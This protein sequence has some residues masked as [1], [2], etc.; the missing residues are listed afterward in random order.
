MNLHY[1]NQ[2]FTCICDA[3]DSLITLGSETSELAHVM[4]EYGRFKLITLGEFEAICT[5]LGCC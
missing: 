1:I 2:S 4:D 5:C 3:D